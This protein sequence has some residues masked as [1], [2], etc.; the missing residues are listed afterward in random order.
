MKAIAADYLTP[1]P[2][3][4]AAALADQVET[5]LEELTGRNCSC[6]TIDASESVKSLVD[7]GES[8][9]QHSGGGSTPA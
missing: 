8:A 4:I 2:T 6:H 5:F 9:S 3:R 7:T 1:L